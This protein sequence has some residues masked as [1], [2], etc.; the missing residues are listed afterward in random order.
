MRNRLR[1]AEGARAEEWPRTV[2]WGGVEEPVDVVR[3]A[4]DERD[5][6]RTRRFRLALADGTVLD[7]SRDEPG[8]DWRIDREVV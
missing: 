7:V 8:G 5:G 3:S 2:V 4:L 1:F 6:V